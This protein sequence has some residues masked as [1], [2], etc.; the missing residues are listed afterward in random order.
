V[1][2]IKVRAREAFEIQ[3]HPPSGIPA[4]VAFDAETFLPVRVSYKTVIA[5]TLVDVDVYH[6]KLRREAGFWVPG[7]SEIQITGNTVKERELVNLR[8][9]VP[10][11]PIIFEPVATRGGWRETLA[12]L[13]FG[14]TGQP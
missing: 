11:E 2:K 7:N 12:R 3:V 8:V 13:P 10:L 1:G 6:R 5:N 14:N 4:Y 9:G